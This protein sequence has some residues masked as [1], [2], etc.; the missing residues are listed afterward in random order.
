[1]DP[2]KL[3]F[4]N[5]LLLMT[6]GKANPLVEILET[7]GF[8]PKQMGASMLLAAWIIDHILP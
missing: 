4:S 6:I 1:M 7:L 3:Q 8:Y 5:D 2:R